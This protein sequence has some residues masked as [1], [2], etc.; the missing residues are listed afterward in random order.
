MRKYK[1]QSLDSSRLEL[2]LIRILPGEADEELRGTIVHEYLTSNPNYVAIS[3][4]WND[5]NLF[6]D[7]DNSRGPDR[8]V[9]DDISFIPIGKNISS[10]LRQVRLV[11]N[12]T[13]NMW[14]DAVC[15]DQGNLSERSAE[16]LHMRK[17]YQMARS[18]Q[19]WLGPEKNDSGLALKLINHFPFFACEG[20]H[21]QPKPGSF[22]WMR[23]TDME[24]MEHDL[25][26]NET[27]K[28]WLA[29]SCLF[30]RAWWN[31]TWVAQEA[32]I[33]NDIVFMCGSATIDWWSIWMLLENL[34]A[35]SDWT[36]RVIP[37]GS[38]LLLTSAPARTIL[39]MRQKQGTFDLLQALYHLRPFQV[40]DPKDKIYGVLGLASDSESIV[41]QPDYAASPT[42]INISLLRS[43]TAV[44]GDLDWLTLLHS[45]D[46]SKD[47]PSWLLDL[48]KRLS[49]VSMNT[50]RSM[51]GA[52]KFGFKACGPT[53]PSLEID[54]CALTCSLQGILVD[55][56]DGLGADYGH[57]FPPDTLI[58]PGSKANAYNTHREV[59]R[60]IW[61]TVVADQG[62]EGTIESWRAPSSVSQALNIGDWFFWN[63][64]L[65]FGQRS[66][67]EWVTRVDGNES[68]DKEEDLDRDLDY[69]FD[70]SFRSSVGG[71]R[72]FTTK[73][74]YL[75]LADNSIQKGDRLYVFL[76]G[77]MPVILR[78]LGDGFRFI[79]ECYTHG[80]MFGEAI[81]ISRKER[82]PTESITIK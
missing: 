76:G 27:R 10:S 54:A 36:T 57:A 20:D 45:Y 32:T 34:W 13:D 11:D 71:R 68:D 47:K 51:L 53:I 8:L 2:R 56:I 33:A 49:V 67:A 37:N 58:Q 4:A 64:H 12:E 52:S 39:W 7:P 75:G 60:A 41:P 40:S 38:T 44:R 78:A 22:T 24:Q 46:G 29:V 82:I 31:R 72:I 43:M 28:M 65:Q 6:S 70:R 15:I 69:Q 48:G 19:I 42:Q 26:S 18:V 81:E 61:K 25:D 74:G 5:D 30:E 59:Y 79:C 9:V 66:I 3:Y 21:S 73:H 80:I 63:Q 77:R 55:E 35:H 23:S 50:S 16:V 1:Y 17:I 14:I 62:F